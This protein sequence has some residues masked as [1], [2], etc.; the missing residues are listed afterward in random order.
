MKLIKDFIKLR[1]KK[2]EIERELR[3]VSK[4]YTDKKN[5][6]L[7]H[8]K[9]PIKSYNEFTKRKTINDRYH[10]QLTTSLVEPSPY[11]RTTFKL[12]DTK[13]RSKKAA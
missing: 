7:D 5:Q 10:I 11:Y 6:I 13:A 1:D 12:T 2:R 9:W 8:V 3:Q 4:E